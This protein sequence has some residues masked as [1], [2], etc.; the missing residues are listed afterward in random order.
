M[1]AT[2]VYKL[3]D[4]NNPVFASYALWT[5]VL[6]LKMFYMSLHT[7]FHRFKNQVCRIRFAIYH[8]KI[9]QNVAHLAIVLD[10]FVYRHSPTSKTAMTR[11]EFASMTSK[12]N[13]FAGNLPNHHNYAYD[14]LSL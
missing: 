3:I 7:A 5:T 11:S 8:M 14:T 9:A 2:P 1:S 10:S 4:L 13:A 12:L 6:A